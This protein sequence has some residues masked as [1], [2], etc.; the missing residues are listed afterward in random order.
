MSRECG[1]V[2]KPSNKSIQLFASPNWPGGYGPE[3]HCEWVLMSP[4]RKQRT[5]IVFV[6]FQ[7]QNSTGCKP[8]QVAIYD[9]MSAFFSVD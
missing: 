5:V 2:L 6:E 4:H 7:L 3:E 1:G 8:D 9:G